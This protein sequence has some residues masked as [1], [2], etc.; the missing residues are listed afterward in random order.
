MPEGQRRGRWQIPVARELCA[1]LELGGRTV[2][3]DALHTR[4][5]TARALMLGH[6]ADY[7][8]TVKGNQPTVRAATGRLVP[9][10]PAAFFP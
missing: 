10:A 7:L 1:R 8:F 6:G 2:S 4:Q 3:L 5:E 9:E